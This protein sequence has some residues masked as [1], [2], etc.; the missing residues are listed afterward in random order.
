MIHPQGQEMLLI[1]IRIEFFFCF[2]PLRVLQIS[3][4]HSVLEAALVLFYLQ[5]QL[6]HLQGQAIRFLYIIRKGEY[7]I[8]TRT[9]SLYSGFS[10]VSRE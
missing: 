10:L 4:I 5:V 3:Q 1:L 7:K 9:S 8:S 2:S 6:I